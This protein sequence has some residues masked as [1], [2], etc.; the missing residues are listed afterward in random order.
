MDDDITSIEKNITCDQYGDALGN[1][2]GGY[3]VNYKCSFEKNEGEDEDYEI[4]SIKIDKMEIKDNDNKIVQD[5]ETEK[6]EFNINE[7]E[8]S[9]LDDHN[10][11]FNKMKI[12]DTSDVILKDQLT[13][14]IIGDLD[15]HINGEKEYEISLKDK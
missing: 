10:Y 6:K 11:T 15:F 1:I 2:N 7:I 4:N 3:L 12:K 5:F 8:S 14:N 9:S 13:F